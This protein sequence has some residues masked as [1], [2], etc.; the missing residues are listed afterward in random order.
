[1]ASIKELLMREWEVALH[2]QSLEFRL[3]KYIILTGFIGFVYWLG[4]WSATWQTL[5]ILLVVALFVHFFYRYMTN[6]WSRAWGGYTP[7]IK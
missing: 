5:V 3:A 2:A 1:M 4:G 6:A 7:R